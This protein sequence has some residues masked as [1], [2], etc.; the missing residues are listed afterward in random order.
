LIDSV[1]IIRRGEDGAMTVESA[2][3]TFSREECPEGGTVNEPT[4]S[5]LEYN[6]R[7]RMIKEE[8]RDIWVEV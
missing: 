1:E 4:G 5:V 2:K 6:L 3:G 7:E 8:E